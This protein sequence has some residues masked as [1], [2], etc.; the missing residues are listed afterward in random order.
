[1]K[2]LRRIEF[3]T[4]DRIAC[5]DDQIAIFQR[6]R[7]YVERTRRWTADDFA[8]GIKQRTVA[9]AMKLFF[10]GAPWHRAA[11]MGAAL[12][13]GQVTTIF[14]GRNEEVALLHQ[15]NRVGLEL[16]RLTGDD[17]AAES[18]DDRPGLK[19]LQQRNARLSE[20]ASQ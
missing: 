1:M 18:T 19:I 8:F 20:Q 5:I 12:P 2:C 17:L 14:Q 10:V 9:R 13:H 7:E 6:D 11:Q 15:I 4:R 3:V 16:F